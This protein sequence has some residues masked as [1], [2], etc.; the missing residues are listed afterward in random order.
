MEISTENNF[1]GDLFVDSPTDLLLILND[2]NAEIELPVHKIVLCASSIYFKKLLTS[3][4][5]KD[6]DQIIIRVPN[7]Y[8][9]YDVIMSFYGK[10]SRIKDLPEWNYELEKIICFDFLGMKPNLDKLKSIDVPIEGIDLLL[11]INQFVGH[12]NNIM[13]LI[14]KTLLTNENIIDFFGKNNSSKTDK[15]LIDKICNYN[16]K[17]IIIACDNLIKILDGK[18]AL[19]HQIIITDHSKKINSLAFSSINSIIVSG[20][21]DHC[22]KLWDTDNGNLIK[23]LIDDAEVLIVTFT[24][25]ETLLVSGNSEGI[26]KIWDPINLSLVQTFSSHE[27]WITSI[28]ISP[29]ND[30]IVYSEQMS[31][32][33][34]DKITSSESHQFKRTKIITDGIFI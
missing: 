5:E 22:I 31:V 13:R 23:T 32:M 7:A 20:S 29:N 1:S 16:H 28:A 19:L 21:D 15:D 6:M 4:K 9:A 34:W 27:D 8:V 12:S 3:F 2:D 10:D 14:N 11:Q 26:I 24:P 30:Q 25:D 18:N 17:K 33:V